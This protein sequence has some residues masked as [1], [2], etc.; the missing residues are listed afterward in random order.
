M[1]GHRLTEAAKHLVAEGNDLDPGGDG[2]WEGSAAVV[3][4]LLITPQHCSDI[5][6]GCGMHISVL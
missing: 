1:L 2:G 4:L 6:A 3:T 5:C